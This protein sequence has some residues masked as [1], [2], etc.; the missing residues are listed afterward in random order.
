M[1]HG[2]KPFVRPL[3]AGLLGLALLLGGFATAQEPDCGGYDKPIVF[4]ELDWD[5]VQVLNHIA[6]FVLEE[7]FGCTTDSI[8]GST[9]PMY[10]GAAR[11]DIDV[12]ME[13]WLDNV[14]DFWGP[15][16]AAGDVVQL[17]AVFDDAIQAFYVPRYMVE[18]DADRGIEA[19]APDLKSVYDLPQYASLFRDPEQPDKGR[20]YNC[21]IGWRCEEI[22]NVKLE[23]YGLTDYFTNFLPGTAVA[24]ATSMEGAYLRG[25]PW[26]GYYW[27]PTWVLGKLDM[28]RL[29]EPPYSDACWDVLEANVDTPEKATEACAYPASTAVIALGKNYKDQASDEIV[30]FLNAIDTPSALINKILAHMQE[31]DASP[32]EAAMHFL[33]TE[34]DVW[35]GWLANAGLDPVVTERVLAALK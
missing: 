24:L 8:P 2:A 23:V 16:V 28:I 19:T 12:V 21:I 29:E 17:D 33:E 26:V 31:T 5:S 11:G 15:A 9:I 25:E 13:V 32:A 14:P 7:G 3:V 18:G 6:R 35:T 22:N 20:F 34:K 4:A 27:S 30:A 1:L 10:R